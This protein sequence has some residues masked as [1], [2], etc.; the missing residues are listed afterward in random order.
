M[1]NDRADG[2][3]GVLVHRQRRE[4]RRVQAA[5]GKEPESVATLGTEVKS[6]TG[7]GNCGSSRTH[8]CGRPAGMD[9][10]ASVALFVTDCSTQQFS[11]QLSGR[12][13]GTHLD[14]GPAA[15]AL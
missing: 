2:C 5:C 12:D 4:K 9:R 6:H 13:T 11:I 10:V 1:R 7:T 15:G 3:R 14:Q 8:P